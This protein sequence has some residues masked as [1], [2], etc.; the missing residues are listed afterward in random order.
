M[1]QGYVV[2]IIVQ[3]TVV[4]QHGPIGQNVPRLVAEDHRNEL[5]L[6]PIPHRRM[7]EKIVHTLVRSMNIEIVEP[8][9]AQ[10][11]VVI[12]AGLIGLYVLHLAEVEK[13]HEFEPAIPPLQLMVDWTALH[14]EMLRRLKK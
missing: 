2:L 3:L 14:L 9:N 11:M 4:I 5:G 1:I 10:L 12:R 13:K 6:A 8:I 7:V